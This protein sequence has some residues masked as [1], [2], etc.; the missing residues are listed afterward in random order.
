M[1]HLPLELSLAENVQKVVGRRL[2]IV[3]RRMKVVGKGTAFSENVAREGAHAIGAVPV[4][5]GN[6]YF[7]KMKKQSTG[8]I[9]V[10]IDLHFE[11]MYRII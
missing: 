1:Q 11:V 4:Q 9:T 10:K 6:L 8:K 2:D 7:L 3:G 5:L